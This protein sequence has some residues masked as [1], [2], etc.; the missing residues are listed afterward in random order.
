[1][2]KKQI[3]LSD[4]LERVWKRDVMSCLESICG[5]ANRRLEKKMVVFN[6]GFEQNPIPKFGSLWQQYNISP[7]IF[8]VHSQP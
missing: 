2:R 8:W 4:L 1:M 7:S 5:Q 3:I 6:L